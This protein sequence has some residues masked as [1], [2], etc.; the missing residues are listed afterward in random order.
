MVAEQNCTDSNKTP[1][2]EIQN[3]ISTTDVVS[4]LVDA[5]QTQAPSHSSLS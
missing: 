2:I 3:G 5:I 1:H 4:E